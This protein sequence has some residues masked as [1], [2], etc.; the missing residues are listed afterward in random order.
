MPHAVVL[1]S[2]SK[3]GTTGGTFADNLAANTGDSLSVANYGGDPSISGA[4]IIEAWAIDAVSVAELQIIYSRPQATHDQSHGL[5]FEIQALVPGGAGTV[6]AQ[7]LMPG[8][9]TV[10]L[11]KSDTPLL[12]VTTTAGDHFLY[13]WLT[14]YDDL[15]G[16]SGVF[17]TWAQVQQL[18]VSAVGISVLAVASATRGAYGAQRAF[19]TDDDR[20]HANTWY[21]I[22]GYTT[23]TPVTTVSLLGPDWGGQRIGGP[24]DVLS[25]RTAT[26]F[27]DQAIKWNKP[28]IPCFNS[29]NKGNVLVQIADGQANTSPKIDFFLYELSGQP[30]GY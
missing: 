17:G 10:D 14:E 13:S 23:Q 27:M 26:W 12:Q 16:V 5:R 11:F 4:R 8:L 29:N 20:L 21:A 6:A 30:G 25:F 24:G 15:P 28:L 19:N 22:L 3:T 18:Q 1:N 9:V 7:E 2:A